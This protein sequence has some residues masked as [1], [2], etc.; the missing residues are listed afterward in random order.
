MVADK[1]TPVWYIDELLNEL[2]HPSIPFQIL[3]PGSGPER[4]VRLPDSP[5]Y[6]SDVLEALDELVDQGE[7][8]TVARN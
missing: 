1:S 8:E 7:G 2:G 4:I 6:Q 3:I 5:L